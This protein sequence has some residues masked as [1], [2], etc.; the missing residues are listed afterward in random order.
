MRATYIST[1][2]CSV[3][4][5]YSDIVNSET[6]DSQCAA[7]RSDPVIRAIKHTIDSQ[8][9]LFLT[10]RL[11][12]DVSNT[13]SEELLVDGLPLRLAELEFVAKEGAFVG[14]PLGDLSA[15]ERKLA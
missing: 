9:V 7:K 11:A 12:F 14:Q 4:G 2:A 13:R 1:S 8:R 10:S 5:Q 6:P 15:A 3:D